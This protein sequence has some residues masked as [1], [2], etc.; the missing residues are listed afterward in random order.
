MIVLSVSPAIASVI[1]GWTSV[2][3]RTTL[4]ASAK[5][6]TPTL[7]SGGN[8]A[9][10]AVAAAFAA[11]N[12]SPAMLLL[13]SIARTVVLVRLLVPPSQ[14]ADLRVDDLVAAERDPHAAWSIVTP[15]ATPL[16]W[17]TTC[18]SRRRGWPC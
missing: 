9:T 11:T 2:G 14:L 16:A 5:V 12:F 13:V 7:T 17:K 4:V 8:A 6:T 15:G 10:K 18:S 3:A 1:A